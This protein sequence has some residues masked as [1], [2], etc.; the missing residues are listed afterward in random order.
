MR[1]RSLRGLS[2]ALVVLALVLV[3]PVGSIAAPGLPGCSTQGAAYRECS[4]VSGADKIVVGSAR[5]TSDFAFWVVVRPPNA[6]RVGDDRE[7]V[8]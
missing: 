1:K 3:V 2:A 5:R 4:F 7:T 8:G 6:R